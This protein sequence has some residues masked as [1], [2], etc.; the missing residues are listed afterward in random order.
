MTGKWFVWK[1][2][3]ESIPGGLWQTGISMRDEGLRAC[4]LRKRLFVDGRALSQSFLED[5][6]C[7]LQ[8]LAMQ[9]E[10]RSA[11]SGR[12]NPGFFLHPLD[13]LHKFRH[14]VHPQKRQEPAIQLEY[15]VVLARFREFEQPNR[16]SRIRVDQA[17][18]PTDC[19]GADRLNQHVVDTDKNSQPVGED[20]PTPSTNTSST[21]T[22]IRN[23]GGQSM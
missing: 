22:K 17:C 15:F 20:L 11:H 18:N 7:N 23:W 4:E 12:A 5:S 16:L 13:E 6:S 21:P 3:Q 8:L 19:A 10:P 14:R 1:I 2:M 9:L